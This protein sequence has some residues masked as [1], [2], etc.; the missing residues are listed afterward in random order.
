LVFCLYLDSAVV[1]NL[2]I[3]SELLWIATPILLYWITRI[4]FL[5]RRRALHQDPIIFAIKDRISYLAG[6][7]LVGIVLLASLTFHGR[8]GRWPLPNRNQV[9]LKSDATK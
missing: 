1:Q 4:W 8:W 5:A 7:A 9:H 2:Y 6:L 3:R